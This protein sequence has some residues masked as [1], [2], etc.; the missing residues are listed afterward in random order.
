MS[1][2]ELPRGSRYGDAESTPLAALSAPPK[3][4]LYEEE[5]KY[6]VPL[7]VVTDY[8]DLN[9]KSATN[10]R[11]DY[12]PPHTLERLIPFALHHLGSELDPSDLDLSQARLRSE[13]LKKEQQFWLHLKGPRLDWSSGRR[14]ELPFAL[15][16]LLYQALKLAA[17]DGTLVKDRTHAVGQVF[18]ERE[19]PLSLRAEIDVLRAAGCNSG[20]KKIGDLSFVLIDV[21]GSEK[22]LNALRHGAH[23]FPFLGKHAIELSGAPDADEVVREAQR[24]LSSR[25]LARKG[26]DEKAR[27]I[28]KK[29]FRRIG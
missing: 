5:A 29:L 8:I 27:A 13:V 19:S 3:T 12:F 18:P 6:F 1:R 14:V 15:D 10:I 11:Q 4:V 23:S 25:R 16:P 9:P 26:F 7:G 2:M 22:A 20:F 28:V 17:T 24:L 21:E